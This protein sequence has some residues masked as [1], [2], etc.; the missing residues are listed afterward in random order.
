M[1]ESIVSTQLTSS[2]V[3]VWLIQY[4]KSAGWLRFMTDDTGK[5]NRA[6]SAVLALLTAAGIHITFDSTA[7]ILTIA[8]IT[9]ANGLHFAWAA[10]QQFVGQ[11][12]IY[13]MVYRPRKAV[14]P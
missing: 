13:E 3:V 8:G 7:G 2:A 11:E 4:L 10:A 5:I 9:L 1:E 14:K 6:V 12:I